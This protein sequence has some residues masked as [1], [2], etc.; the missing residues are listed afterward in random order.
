MKTDTQSQFGIETGV[1]DL[2]HI[3]LLFFNYGLPWIVSFDMA[4]KYKFSI[5]HGNKI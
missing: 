4:I 1:E 2:I 3:D 5:S